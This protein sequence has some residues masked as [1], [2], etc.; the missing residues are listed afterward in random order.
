M[1]DD[2]LVLTKKPLDINQNLHGTDPLIKGV[3]GV[4]PGPA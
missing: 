3:F 1:I 2:E 4:E